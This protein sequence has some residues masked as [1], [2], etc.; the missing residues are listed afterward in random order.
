MIQ[1]RPELSLSRQCQL[2]HISRSSFYSRP[3]GESPETLGLM[4]QIDRL[5]MQY[6]FYGSRQMV[7]QLRR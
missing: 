4:Q 6:P 2:L 1:S 5:Y 7:W 3:I